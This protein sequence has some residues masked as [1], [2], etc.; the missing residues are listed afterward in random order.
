MNRRERGSVT[1]ELALALPAVALLLAAVLV[2]TSAAVGQLRCAD[3]AR[4]GARAAAL[5]EPLDQVRAVAARVAGGAAAIVIDTHAGWVT[6]SVSRAVVAGPF[7]GAPLRAHASA[8]ARVEPL[9][10]VA[11]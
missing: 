10:R 7:A 5:G 11:P 8:S 2:L 3:A 1:V 6:V 9:A 4:A